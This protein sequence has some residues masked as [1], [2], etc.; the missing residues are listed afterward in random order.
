[1]LTMNDLQALKRRHFAAVCACSETGGLSVA[2]VADESARLS[3]RLLHE[4]E[5]ALIE[6]QQYAGKHREVRIPY[7]PV[8][9][10]QTALPFAARAS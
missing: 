10:R 9:P 7:A 2:E 3:A 5:L 1:M 4:L 8:Q 6:R